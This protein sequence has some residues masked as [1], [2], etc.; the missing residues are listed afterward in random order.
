MK[1]AAWLTLVFALV[2]PACAPSLCGDLVGPAMLP[3]SPDLPRVSTAW[4]DDAL[5]EAPR[6]VQANRPVSHLL[7]SHCA[8]GT[9][10]YFPSLD[11]FGSQWVQVDTFEGATHSGDRAQEATVCVFFPAPDVVPSYAP[12]SPRRL[13]S[14]ALEGELWENGKRQSNGA[15][16]LLEAG[17]VVVARGGAVARVRNSVTKSAAPPPPLAIADD[18]HQW[19][20]SASDG[21]SVHWLLANGVSLERHP[22]GTEVEAKEYLAGQFP[23]YPPTKRVWRHGT[24]VYVYKAR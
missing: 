2:L 13:P 16:F 3:P 24:D 5:G 4:H 12:Q 17:V 7:G 11:G 8:G 18:V 19:T 9:S 23:L 21:R 20:Y 1:N 14:G 22:H 10:G 6:W 15:T